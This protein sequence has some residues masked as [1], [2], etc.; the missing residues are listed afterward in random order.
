MIYGI[1]FNEGVLGFY[2][3]KTTNMQLATLPKRREL[4]PKLKPV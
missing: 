2:E 4:N 1:F 3:R